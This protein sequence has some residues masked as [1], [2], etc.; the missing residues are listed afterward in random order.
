MVTTPTVSHGHAPT[1]DEVF[2][3]MSEAHR[4][5]VAL[6]ATRIERLTA[7][8]R[9]HDVPVP[10]EDPR[11]GISDGE[12]LIACRLVVVAAYELLERLEDLK[13]I[14]GSGMELVGKERWR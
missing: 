10:E 4:L 8:L 9:E 14:V 6:L 12:H 13:R 11:L 7:L 3:A 1:S 5:E 2:L